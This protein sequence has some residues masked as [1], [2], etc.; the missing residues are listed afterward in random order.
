MNQMED[1]LE[2]LKEVEAFCRRHGLADSKFGTLTTINDTHL[3]ER[4]RWGLLRRS[5][6][7]K[8]R[9]FMARYELDAVA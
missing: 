2:L 8:V 5:T 9:Q 6:I 7:N 3:V 4:M 1:Q